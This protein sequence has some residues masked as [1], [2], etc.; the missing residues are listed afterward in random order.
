M[1][2]RGLIF[3][4]L[5]LLGLGAAFVSPVWGIVCYF[6]HYYLWPENQWWGKILATAGIR[7]SLTISAVAIFTTAIHWPR[8][9]RGWD[10]LL[11]PQ[12]LLLWAFVAVIGICT[13]FGLPGDPKYTM[14]VHPFEKMSKIAIFAFLLTHVV[15]TRRDLFRLVWFMVLVGGFYLAFVAFQSPA[16]RFV[17]G[18]L[19]GI[20]GPDFTNSNFLANHFVAMGILTALLLLVTRS[21]G[22]R[23]VLLGGG[24][25]VAN[26]LV[27][28]RS[29]GAFLAA[30]V[31]GGAAFVM[32][33]RRI[34][35][36]LLW[37]TPLV[38]VGSLAVIDENFIQRISTITAGDQERD[39]SA[40][41]R[42]EFWGAALRI[43]ADY[44]LGI[45][46]DRF[47]S[48]IGQYLPDHPG[49][50][51]HSTYLRCLAELGIFGLAIFL[52]LFINA[53]R[54]LYRCRQDAVGLEDEQQLR[55]AGFALQLCLIGYAVGGLTSTMTYTE[56]VFILLML[57]VCLHRAV[58][59]AWAE[60]MACGAG[61]DEMEADD[62]ADSG[63]AL[64]RAI[65][66]IPGSV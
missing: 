1:G 11:E 63:E 4:G 60:Q 49:R 38:I 20:G 62:D 10:R 34:R 12:E 51:P 3:I 26:A 44:P 13:L 27:M 39:A 41:G 59:N 16:S 66:S 65:S 14:T 52:A 36:K 47:S 35:R 6:G 30:L 40:A 9:R 64:L 53:F 57:P 19:Q 31:A 61:Y 58:Q 46:A 33:D 54:M 22:W 32:A 43:F 18:R 15:I 56:E 24:A 48:T 21:V 8:L 29:R 37:L 25:L 45:G 55:Y 50:D 17:D 28:T 7:V 2:L 23:L 5:F 42:L